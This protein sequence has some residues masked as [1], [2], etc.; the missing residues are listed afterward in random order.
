M[1]MMALVCVLLFIGTFLCAYLPSIIRASP[2]V[3]NLIAIF[4]GA[5][6][7]G[8]ALVIIV[9]ESASI[10]INAQYSLNLMHGVKMNQNEIVTEEMAGTIGT[11]IMLGF[12]TMFI[13]NEGFVILQERASQN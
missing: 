11:G 5:T 9:P 6:I 10:L 2:K 7:I 3:L 12:A 1:L 4:G 13:I 8:A